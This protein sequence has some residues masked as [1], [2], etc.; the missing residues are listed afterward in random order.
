MINRHVFYKMGVLAEASWKI[1]LLFIHKGTLFYCQCQVLD[2]HLKNIMMQEMKM[3]NYSF[4][5]ATG[6]LR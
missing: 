6:I 5:A 2:G 3:D 4:D 1:K